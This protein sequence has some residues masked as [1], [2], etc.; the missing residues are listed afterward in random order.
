MLVENGRS[1]SGVAAPIARK[2][3]DA[4]LLPPD[5]GSDQHHDDDARRARR[6]RGMRTEI[7]GPGYSSRAQRTFTLTGRAA[8]RA[9]P[10]RAA[11]ARV[12][13]VCAA[14]L[15][16]LFSA[17]GENVSIFLGQAARVGARARRA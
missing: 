8:R 11:A 4:Y 14:G 6:R 9:A 16:V 12:L 1:G 15:V 10:R 13:A 17:A 3:L 7:A 2:V 5:H